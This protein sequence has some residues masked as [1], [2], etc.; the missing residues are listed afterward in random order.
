MA[1]LSDTRI[2]YIC[3]CEAQES[4]ATLRVYLDREIP[5][6]TR[7]WSPRGRGA[8]V[9][10]DTLTG[11]DTTWCNIGSLI[12][13]ST[14]ASTKMLELSVPPLVMVQK[15]VDWAG[16]LTPFTSLEQFVLTSAPYPFPWALADIERSRDNTEIGFPSTLEWIVEGNTG[17]RV[18]F[19]CE[20][21]MSE[22]FTT[23]YFSNR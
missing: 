19:D 9:T 16:I 8:R 22:T 15:N 10:I 3:V 13:A 20:G 7:G 5:R 1:C 12:P 2:Q 18:S 11:G 17:R 14:A 4:A 21:S 23:T 6:V